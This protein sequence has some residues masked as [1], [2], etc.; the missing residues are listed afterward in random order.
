MF[1]CYKTLCA[2]IVLVLACITLSLN[3]GCKPSQ[4]KLEERQAKL[5]QIVEATFEQISQLESEQKSDEANELIAKALNNPDFESSKGRLIALKAGILIRENN[6]AKAEEMIMAELK[7]S[8]EVVGEAL[9]ALFYHYNST[10]LF[11]QSMTLSG[12]ILNSDISLPDNMRSGILGEK[13]AAAVGLD[14]ADIEKAVI[15]SIMSSV[16][17]SAQAV[18][19]IEPHMTTLIRDKKYDEALE[20][21]KHIQSA[22]KSD[23]NYNNLAAVINIQCVVASQNWKELKP[24]YE[25]SL[26]Q[27]PDAQ[28][29]KL[30][31]YVFINLKKANKSD[32]LKECALYGITNTPN[33]QKSTDYAAGKWV[34]T[35][36]TENKK[37]LPGCLAALTKTPVSP[38]KSGSIFDRY[39]YEVANDIALVKE[40]CKIGPELITKCTDEKIANSLKVKILD[41]A[42]I[43]E[44]YDLAVSMLE[45]G[46]PG[47]DKAWHDMSLPK[48]KAHRAQAQK[49]PRDAVKYYREFMACWESSEKEEEFDPTSGIAYSKEWILARNANRIAEILQSIPDEAEA[50]KA[51]DEAKAYFKVAIE[52]AKDDEAALKLVKEEAAKLQ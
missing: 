33:K 44:D 45:K 7:S 2:V 39:F 12:K 11:E 9:R 29:S 31:R 17:E 41:G 22:E 42:F 49:K 37:S 27:L 5:E 10:K 8:P 26:K 3:S 52:K 36:F 21:A 32:L 38:N 43:I 20:L 34:E 13:L 14:D 51:R 48:V 23:D 28:V 30:M 46:I 18:A 25:S 47:K 35:C 24:V 15:D 50:A 19:I 6:V 1:N 16:K 4:Q 40:L